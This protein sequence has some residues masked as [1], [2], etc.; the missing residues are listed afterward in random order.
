MIGRLKAMATTDFVTN[1]VNR[2]RFDKV[3]EAAF[4]KSIIRDWPLSLIMVDVD[5]FKSYNDTFGHPAGDLVL[6]VV[7][8]HL[9]ESARSSDVVAR[10]GG[11]EFAIMV[12][13]ADAAIARDCVERY[14]DSME[15]FH[16]PHRAVAAS[17]G[18]ATRTPMIGDAAALVAQADRALYDSKRGGRTRVIHPGMLDATVPSTHVSPKTLAGT[19]R[20]HDEDDRGSS[21][22]DESFKLPK[23]FER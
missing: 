14:R 21:Q 16:W 3:L 7:A 17:F 12:H 4:A 13:E 5:S 8:R 1:L 22:A 9:L 15:S 11:D 6:S 18:V 10:Y 20:T 19:T 23:P 2:R